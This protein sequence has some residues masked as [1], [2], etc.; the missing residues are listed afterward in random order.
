MKNS[1]VRNILAIE[2][3]WILHVHVW[4]I[5]RNLSLCLQVDMSADLEL[6]RLDLLAVVIKYFSQRQR[7]QPCDLGVLPG[8]HVKA[9]CLQMSTIISYQQIHTIILACCNVQVAYSVH[10]SHNEP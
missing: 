3:L 1:T 4:Q 5:R 10:V 9:S 8:T 7:L 6:S 2:R